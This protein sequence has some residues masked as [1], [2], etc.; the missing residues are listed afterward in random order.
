MRALH[1]Q[2]YW[3]SASTN[4]LPAVHNNASKWRVSPSSH[5]ESLI[6]IRILPLGTFLHLKAIPA[7]LELEIYF[8]FIS[9]QQ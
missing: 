5:L 4:H 3:A 7:A 9:K 8:F 6:N 2:P 1:P